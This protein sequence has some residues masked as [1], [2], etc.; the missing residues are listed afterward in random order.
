[1]HTMMTGYEPAK[2]TELRYHFDKHLRRLSNVL[3]FRGVYYRETEFKRGRRFEYYIRGVNSR[4][5]LKQEGQ[6]GVIRN[7]ENRTD[8]LYYKSLRGPTDL[9][10]SEYASHIVTIECQLFIFVCKMRPFDLFLE[11]L[12]AILC[13]CTK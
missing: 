1:M 7:L 10:S 8:R 5:R 11:V 6:S 9:F 13:G 3:T 12:G 4:G 2:P